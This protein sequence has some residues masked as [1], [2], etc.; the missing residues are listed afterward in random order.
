M[1]IEN[2]NTNEI[3][4]YENNQ[5]IHT[6]EQIDKIANSINEYG[7]TQPLVIDKNNILIVGHGRLRASKKLNFKR[8]SSNKNG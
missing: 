1:K 3:I 7:F 4:K 2:M 8:S 6:T 5:R